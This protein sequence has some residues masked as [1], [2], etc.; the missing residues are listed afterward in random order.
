MSVSPLEHM[1]FTNQDEMLR[2]FFN[3]KQ[4][5]SCGEERFYVC[6]T[7]SSNANSNA[8]TIIFEA[9]ARLCSWGQAQQVLSSHMKN[10]ELLPA[11]TPTCGIIQR[12]FNLKKPKNTSAEH[13]QKLSSHQHESN[14]KSKEQ[15]IINTRP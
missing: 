9:G 3:V 13:R 12:S 8:I 10:R 5:G 4:T 11:F 1:V 14:S 7:I 2:S 6:Y 15:V